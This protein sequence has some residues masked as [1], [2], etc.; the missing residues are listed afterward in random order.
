MSADSMIHASSNRRFIHKCYLH[1]LNYF[2]YCAGVLLLRERRLLKKTVSGIMLTVLLA[3]MLTVTWGQVVHDVAV[4]AIVVNPTTV[5][6]GDAVAM[7]VTVE[8]QGTVDEN[9]GVT[10]Y[11]RE[12][13]EP[14]AN[15]I[16][17]RIA[18][19]GTGYSNVLPFF[20]NTTGVAPGTYIIS[21]EA[22]ILPGEVDTADN[23]YVDGEVQINTRGPRMDSLYIKYYSS[24]S[25]LYNALKNG[26]V[27][28]T[29]MELNE[30][31]MN[32][33]FNDPNIQA[34]IS[35][36]PGLFEFD[37]NNNATTPTYPN[38]TNPTAY[39][40]FR[41]GIAYL[42]NKTHIVNEIAERYSYR[43]DTPVP[44]PAGD[45]WVDSSVSQYDSYGNLLGN[46]PYEYDPNT[47]AYY[48]N[49]SG[50]VE[51]DVAQSLGWRN[52]SA[53]PNPYY[54]SNFP[55]SA[56]YLRVYPPGHPNMGQDLDLL[57]FYIRNDHQPRL[58][59]GRILRDNLRRMGIPINATEGKKGK[60]WTKVM[61][62]RD[63][64]IYT[65][66]WITDSAAEY[67]TF[68]PIY[69]SE[70]IGPGKANYV[71]FRN[72]TYDEW[73]KKL[74]ESLDITLARE[75]ALK[76]QRILIEE[77]VSVW[78]WTPSW[79]MGYRNIYGVVN[80]RGGRIDNPWTFLN[81]R[82]GDNVTRTEIYY[83]LWSP[84]TSLNIVTDYWAWPGNIVGDAL[85]RIYDTLLSYNPYEKSPGRGGET[86][87]WVAEDW[88][89]GTWESPYEPGNNLTK[90]TFHLRDGIRW[91][92]RV[93]L[94]SSDIKFT[95]EYL[96]Q[97][98]SSPLYWY[99]SDVHHV[100]TPDAHT[101]AV[102]E[103][104]SNTW[105]L[106][107]IG[108]LPILPKHIFQNIM[109]VTGYT[110]GASEGWPAN[111]T[112]IGS[113][114]WKY[115][116]HN[117]SM[118]RLEANGDYFMETPPTAEIDFRYDWEMGSWVVD[119][120]DA[121]MVGEANGSSGNGIPDAKWEPGGDLNSDGTINLSDMI[122]LGQE[123]NK[124][125]GASAK[126]YITPPPTDTAIYVEPLGNTTLVGQNLTVYVKL[127]NLTKL[128]GLQFKLN[129]DNIKLDLLDLTLTKIFGNNTYEVK[130]EVNQTKGLVW[131]SIS[132]LGLTQ[133][134]SGNTTLATITFNATKPSGSL[135][136]LWNTKLASYGAP[137]TTSQLMAH[138]AV[139]QGVMVGVLT[140]TGTNVI[141]APA[142]NAQVTFT[143]TTIEGVT[144]LNIT[145]PPSPEFVSVRV[146]D[147]KTTATYTGNITIQFA[148][149]PTGLSLE[150]EQSMK[151][152]FWNETSGTWVD[153]TTLVDT[154]N[155][156][157]YG[158]TTHLSI[159]GI[160]SD[161][162]VEGNLSEWGEIYATIPATPPNPPTGLVLLKYYEIIT[163][164][165]YTGN[166]TIRLAYNDNAVPPEEEI[167]IQMWRW[168]ETSGTWVDTTTLVDTTNNIIY[169]VTTHLSIF[170]IT[171]LTPPPTGIAVVNSKTSKTVVGQGYSV[172]IDFTVVNQ[173][174]FS[175]KNFN[176]VVYGN[177]TV[178]ATF[179][180]TELK[181]NAQID[182][183]FTWETTGWAKGN[184]AIS[185]FAHLISWVR[186]AMV[187]DITGGPGGTPDG[188]VDIMDLASIA[189]RYG[190]YTGHP[191]Y[192]AE[193]DIND[194]GNIDIIDLALCAKQYGKIDP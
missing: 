158:V 2:N 147:I 32:E 111:Q 10:V 29:D 168:N 148:Y 154:I 179:P 98:S 52:Q 142:E 91:H 94:N 108:L 167:F 83:G 157:I 68:L 126:R 118:L 60:L 139:D 129:Y 131:V 15:T 53:T 192:V 130:K 3:S 46:Y 107:Y 36:E 35:P 186:V 6:V 183:S 27:D 25:A 141:I 156:I 81:A 80:F 59:A 44:R 99:I 132:S 79:V 121:T 116:S 12:V 145:Q 42:V 89:I 48:F 97:Q 103:N 66:G 140:P 174:D 182:L 73:V 49:Q 104:V 155:N 58:E 24:K 26:E 143:N 191:K 100:T 69:S 50:F 119:G 171:S 102:Y 92:D 124:T 71:Q 106:D 93:E 65:A 164:K 23:V 144:T 152:W 101:V 78:L 137:G 85:N 45:W 128:S 74:Q 180:I 1:E 177:S 87:P 61:Q 22:S 163:T 54:N 77:A 57:N 170:G 67:Q 39:K 151:I 114:P 149:D 14:E 112:L 38:W 146:Y 13:G 56:Q 110:P 5:D 133:P 166:V 153:I 70:E 8:N 173:G 194:D 16:A 51:G 33:V 9:F 134:V 175:L 150:D 37:F 41:Q 190:T 72:A 28:L 11:Y 122:V 105:T 88:E 7:N 40:G 4:V 95:I 189:S 17:T 127:K 115:V 138:K 193:W 161:L 165:S 188:K 184:Y 90:L 43:I 187:G 172:T 125:W 176:V 63:Y 30:T 120:M 178:L 135:L 18:Y 185:T 159:F 136:D 113:G 160:T 31:Q 19:V 76:A 34:A 64:H 86:M 117:S 20:W 96:Q 62:E 21:A 181:P 169:G 82:L 84:P 75:A 47:A 109:N 123:F 162:S 55:S